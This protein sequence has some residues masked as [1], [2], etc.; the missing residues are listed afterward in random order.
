MSIPLFDCHCDSAVTA[1]EA[2]QELRRNRL[3]IDLEHLCAYSPAVQVFAVCA[4]DA[5]QPAKFA[6]GA[7]A[8][9]RAQLNKNRDIVSLCLTSGDIKAAV[10]EG[11]IA[12]L[13]SIEGAEQ[14]RNIDEAYS[15]GVRIVHITWNN[16]NYLCGAA[17]GSGSGLTD[18]GR[19]FVKRAQ[20]LGIMLDMSHIS[21]CGFWDTLAVAHGPIIAGH[22]DSKALCAHP[23]NLSD[24]QFC[25]LVKTGGGAGINLCPD[26]L[27][28]GR[29]IDAVFA[30]IEHFL[31]LG[32]ERS[33]FLGC[34]LDGID[35]MPCGMSGVQDLGKI[36][37]ILLRHNYS[38]ALARDIFFGNLMRITEAA[39]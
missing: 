37:E 6:D 13:L 28:L 17:M 5:A 31:E 20:E 32:G 33:V 23:R 36:Y 35:E 19:S 8:Y 22:S 38:E 14:L 1:W 4:A 16:D 34:D 15:A 24:E 21:E 3:H 18:K 30:H 2:G 29:D 7:L 12:A 11:K 27:G 26:F 39:L 25:A 9:F 10:S